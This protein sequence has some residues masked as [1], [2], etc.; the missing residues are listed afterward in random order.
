MGKALLL[1]CSSCASLTP[2]CLPILQLLQAILLPENTREHRT[3]SPGDPLQVEAG[4]PS[5]S[6][7]QTEPQHFKSA[8]QNTVSWLPHQVTIPTFLA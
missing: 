7:P 4:V 3:G 6:Y 5:P 1:H 2:H 8:Q